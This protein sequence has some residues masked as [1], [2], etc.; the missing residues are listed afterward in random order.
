[1]SSSVVLITPETL[2][3]QPGPHVDLL[4][5]AGFEI[6]YPKNRLLARGACDVRETVDELCGCSAVIA[7]TCRA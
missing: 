3:D 5:E 7:F 4:R 1:M 2:L 6:R